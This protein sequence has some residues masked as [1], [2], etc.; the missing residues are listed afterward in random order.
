LT[1]LIAR[2]I[3]QNKANLELIAKDAPQ[4]VRAEKIERTLGFFLRFVLERVFNAILGRESDI[5]AAIRYGQIDPLIQQ[6][7]K[8]ASATSL[9]SVLLSLEDV[10][11]DQE[12]SRIRLIRV[13]S[14]T[15]GIYLAYLLQIDAAVYL[16][17]AVPG[18]E[19]TIN[20]ANNAIQ[21]PGNLTVGI[22][23]TGFAASAGSKFW[24]DILTRLQETREQTE[25]AARLAKKVREMVPSEWR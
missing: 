12:A 13:F 11:Q 19:N 16:G 20:N 22:I 23:L 7:I 8:S 6:T 18:I 3:E 15:T 1:Y 14:I 17:Y 10:H 4:Y 9:A 25:E 21:L 2:R 5:R 24:R